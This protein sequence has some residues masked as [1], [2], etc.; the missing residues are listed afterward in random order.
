M[1]DNRTLTIEF[2]EKHKGELLLHMDHVVRLKGFYEDDDYY[3]DVVELGKNQEAG[4]Q[5]VYI[6][7]CLALIPLKG[8]LDPEDYEMLETFFQY[9]EVF[10]EDDDKN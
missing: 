1:T 4:P 6:S 7:C 8:Q 9:N 10:K 3:Y 5:K 2:V